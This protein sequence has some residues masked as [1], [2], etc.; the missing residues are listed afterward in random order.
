MRVRVCRS[1]LCLASALLVMAVTATFT[2][3]D[4]DCQ[5]ALRATVSDGELSGRA[6]NA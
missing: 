3:P 6:D 4:C 5:C 2:P 1:L